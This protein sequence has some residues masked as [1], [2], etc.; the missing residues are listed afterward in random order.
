MK[1]KFKTI[2][3]AKT[4]IALVMASLCQDADGSYRKSSQLFRKA[5]ERATNPTITAN[6]SAVSANQ[7]IASPQANNNHRADNPENVNVEVV[8]PNDIN[9]VDMG[10]NVCNDIDDNAA[11]TA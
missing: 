5:H 9:N 7:Q 4:T 1:D 10:N 8:I 6:S 11:A 3:V 2:I